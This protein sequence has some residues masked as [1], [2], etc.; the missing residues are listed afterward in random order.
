[1]SSMPRRLAVI[2]LQAEDERM[3]KH[4]GFGVAVPFARLP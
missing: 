4:F 2:T 3:H 1:M